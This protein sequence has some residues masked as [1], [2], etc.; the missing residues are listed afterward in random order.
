MIKIHTTSYLRG[1]WAEIYAMLALFFR[2]YRILAWRYKTPVG[3]VDIVAI[4]RNILVFVEVKLRPDLDQGYAAV[5]PR[6]QQRITRAANHFIASHHKFQ[7]V[8]FRFDVM[9]VAGWRL[10]HLDNAWHCPP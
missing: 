6:S 3:E 7:G 9:A 5:T 10:R 2:G 1:L 8:S 4:R